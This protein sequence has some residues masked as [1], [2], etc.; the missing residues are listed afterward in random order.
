MNKFELL[1]E[2]EDMLCHNLLCYSANYLMNKPKKQYV[3]EWEETQEKISLVE[4]M[5]EYEKQK[6][7]SDGMAFTK[8]QIMKMY[9]NV[10]YQVKNSNGGLLAGTVELEDAKKYAEKYKKEYLQ[11]SLNNKLE[12][13]VLNKRGEEVYRANGTQKNIE[14]EET[15][16]FE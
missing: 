2:F 1:K 4:E 9:P 10:Q 6:E 15:E 16:E 14:T 5:M 11:D 3:K 12:V 7:G 8:D 13:F